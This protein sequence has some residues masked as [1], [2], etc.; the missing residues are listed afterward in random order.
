MANYKNF[1]EIGRVCLVNYG[2]DKDKLCTII[3]IVDQNTALVD[4]PVD[5]TG[6]SRKQMNFK[7]L[8]ITPLKVNIARGVRTP[9]LSK[10]FVKDEILEK[11]NKSSW[12]NR[13]KNQ[14]IRQSLSDFQR[15]QLMVLR[16]KKSDIVSR[17]L[18]VVKRE[19][20]AASEKKQ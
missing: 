20:R 5:K 3:D 16:K 19:K 15:F 10:Q 13:I 4:G 2:P 18:A 14:K 17:Q 8:A 12:A 6:V 1:V 9:T 7:R 11:W